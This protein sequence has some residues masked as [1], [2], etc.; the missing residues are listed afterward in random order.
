MDRL[1]AVADVGQGAAHDDA[2]RVVE[3]ADPHLVLDADGPDVAEV[4]GHGAATPRSGQV[5]RWLGGPAARGSAARTR[6]AVSAAPR[7]RRRRRGRRRMPADD[8]RESSA[9][10]ARASLAQGVA[11]DPGPVAVVGRRGR[12][13]PRARRNAVDAPRIDAAPAIGAPTRA[14]SGRPARRRRSGGR[15]APGRG[16][17]TLRRRARAGGRTNGIVAIVEPTSRRSQRRRRV[18]ELLELGPA[19]RL[20]QDARAVRVGEACRR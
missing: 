5:Q 8:G 2:H 4:V 15:G 16:A 19:V 17:A 14:P 13:P 6:A 9:A 3:V 10:S 20:A 12:S 1:E 18:D 11:D 7:R